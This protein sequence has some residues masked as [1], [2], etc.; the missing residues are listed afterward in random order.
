MSLSKKVKSGPETSA[1]S[2]MILAANN[3]F[4]MFLSI[5]DSTKSQGFDFSYKTKLIKSI[6]SLTNKDIEGLYKCFLMEYFPYLEKSMHPQFLNNLPIKQDEFKKNF[7][8]TF[9]LTKTE[10]N[11]LKEVDENYDSAFHSRLL[12]RK[13]GIP[14][15]V[16][17]LYLIETIEEV[18][19]MIFQQMNKNIVT[20]LK[21][22]EVQKK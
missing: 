6:H 21:L 14:R 15:N 11:L 4:A 7:I 8:T 18:K 10:L 3:F 13:M 9:K 19:S 1:F 22:S 12:L 16:D 2:Y 17:D 20:F 5:V